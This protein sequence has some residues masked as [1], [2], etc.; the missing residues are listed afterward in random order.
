[1]AFAASERSNS[2]VLLANEMLN[3]HIDC[4][5][6]KDDFGQL[7]VHRQMFFITC[8]LMRNTV[9]ILPG[10]G[11]SAGRVVIVVGASRNGSDPRHLRRG[12]RGPGGEG[13]GGRCSVL[14]RRG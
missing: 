1:M 2:P 9:A 3:G 14:V 8:H 5:M 13:P 7:F 10:R 12:F 4:I 11:L 6:Q